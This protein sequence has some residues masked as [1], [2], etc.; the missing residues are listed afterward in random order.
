MHINDHMTKIKVRAVLLD[1]LVEW[2]RSHLVFVYL[3]FFSEVILDWACFLKEKLWGH[4]S[5]LQTGCPSCQMPNQ[6]CQVKA[7]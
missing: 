3:A 7:D 2:T 4:W 1:H 5:I 6:Q